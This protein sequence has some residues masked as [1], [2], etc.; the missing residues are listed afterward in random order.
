MYE[1][2]AIFTFRRQ[3]AYHRVAQSLY[4][5]RVRYLHGQWEIGGAYWYHF[6]G[7]RRQGRM[8]HGDTDIM[9]RS[10]QGLIYQRSTFHHCS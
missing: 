5:R 1:T 3:N 2:V 7:Y 9:N 6:V 8:F 10:G 4:V